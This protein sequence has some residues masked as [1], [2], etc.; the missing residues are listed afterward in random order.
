MP[1]A[2]LQAATDQGNPSTGWGG[3]LNAV[4]SL[5]GTAGNL[6]ST[7]TGSGE[8]KTPA[9]ITATVNPPTAPVEQPKTITSYLPW[10]LGGAAVLVVAFL[11]LRRR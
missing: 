9:A 8:N 6:Y 2:N 11:F 7:V 4:T 5:A 1:E 10:I 3:L